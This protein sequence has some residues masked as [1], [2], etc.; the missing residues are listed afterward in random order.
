MPAAKETARADTAVTYE[1]TVKIR[2]DIPAG[3]WFSDLWL[4]TNLPGAGRVRVPVAI[5]VEPSVSATPGRVVLGAVPPGQKV[6][7]KVIVKAAKP[8]KIRAITGADNGLAAQA[9]GDESKPLH[10]VTL[11]YASEQN[12]SVGWQLKVKTDLAGDIVLDL[13]VT[14]TADVAQK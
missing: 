14:A 5:D 2:N 8:F 7:R 1:I 3:K 6:E 4:T 9:D 12:A 11:T 13:P 10:V